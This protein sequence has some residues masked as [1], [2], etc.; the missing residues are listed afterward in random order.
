[1][2][3]DGDGSSRNLGRGGTSKG[4]IGVLTEAHFD[5]TEFRRFN[6]VFP[7]RG[8]EVVYL[9]HL[10]GQPK[11]S[12][13][14]NDFTAE[15]TV[16]TEVAAADPRDYRAIILIGGYAMDRLR[17]QEHPRE[18]MANTAPAV[19][20]LR[21][22][23]AAMDDG[24]IKIGTICHSLWLFCA[25]PETIRGRRVT[26]AHN[27]MP[28][29]EHAGAILVYDGDQ[30]ADTVVDGNLISAR[31]PGVVDQFLDEFLAELDRQPVLAAMERE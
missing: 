5:E 4:R 15:S 3:M 9:S 25:A 2:M 1:M 23:V 28:D 19:E 14:G 13:T 30:L 27:I 26:C 11:L 17:Y 12:F 21:R 8:F 16:T 20:F 18:G 29:V 22:A 24:A 6:E 7:A 10:W 31:H